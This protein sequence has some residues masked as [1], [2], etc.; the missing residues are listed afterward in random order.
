MDQG[1][2]ASE[3]ADHV[4]L[5][6][7]NGLGD[8]ENY[9]RG[10]NGSNRAAFDGESDL[11][12]DEY[13]MRIDED[14]FLRNNMTRRAL[15]PTGCCYDPRMKL[16]ANADF[17]PSPHHPED[18]RRIEE[19]MK[20]LKKAEL[21]YNGPDTDLEDILRNTP[22]K[23][24]WR[25]PARYA[26]RQEICTMHTPQHYD[27]VEDLSQKDTQEL[28]KIS[29]ELDQGRDSLYVGA[30]SFEAALLAAGGAIET[31]KNV[32]LGK[33]KNGLAIIRPP[34]HHAEYNAPMGFCLFNN[35]P[36]A[37][38][39]CQIEF[40]ETCRKILILDWDV[41][42]G[43]GVQNMFYDDPNVLYIS[44]HVY[45]NGEFYPGKPDNPE[46]PDGGI[47]QVG[48][49]VGR[50]KNVNIG[51][52]NQGMGDGEYLAAFQEIVMPIAQEFDPDMVIISA[53]FD[54]ADGDE[55]GGCFVSPPC[56]AHMTHMLMSLA[57]G[58]VAVCLEGGYNLKAI[59]MSALAVAR[60]LM[61][62]PPPKISL[63]R[64]DKDAH[65]VLQK[66]KATQ[67]PYWD[68]MRKG[69]IDVPAVGPGSSRLHDVIRG[70][71]RQV[72]AEKCGLIPLFIQREALFKSFENQVLI[73]PGIMEK[74][75]IILLIHDPPEL[76]AMPDLIDNKVDPHNAFV[77]DGVTSYIEWAHQNDFGIIDANIPHY[78]THPEDTDPYI[79]GADERTLS[80]QMK[81]LMNY[82]WDN[83]LQLWE[84]EDIFLVGVGNAYLGVKLLLTERHC[85]DRISGVINFVTGNLR[86]V[87]SSVDEDL[88]GWYKRNSLVY[89]ADD[90]A[91]WIDADMAK[92]VSKKRFGGVK[93]SSQTGL[94]KMMHAHAG[95]VHEWIAERVTSDKAGDDSTDED[96]DPHLAG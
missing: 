36:I 82:I 79:Q 44:L 62:E 64:I 84:A 12:V 53:G 52:I 74:R 83:Y 7:P 41:H 38:K 3:G 29:N 92:K 55:L 14:A 31:C 11:E 16:H 19:I 54:A 94:N 37:A 61:G 39:I 23:Y 63:P 72:L 27:W 56:Y 17:G 33:I 58:K 45:A 77:M 40:P 71:Q 81:E 8:H 67:A 9:M 86:P 93:R 18:P 25:I 89:V 68:C 32:A 4:M 59:S 70:Y 15:L 34:G 73:S 28:R 1:H 35:V 24:M 50:G 91:C 6:V 22:T 26:T 2:G 65:K 66:V 95:E 90:H 57:G 10:E 85:K 46:I 42:H 96:T 47:E 76:V 21:V 60:T 51:W 30:M 88:S 13:D 87:K 49:G 43:N 78:I 80:I 20:M 48:E 69:V 75:K 5:D